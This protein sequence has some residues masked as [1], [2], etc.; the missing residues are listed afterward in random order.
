MMY[1]EYVNLV[2]KKKR[3]KNRCPAIYAR[4]RFTSSSQR[5]VLVVHANS[6]KMLRYVPFVEI[7][8]VGDMVDVSWMIL[9]RDWRIVTRAGRKWGV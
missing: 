3:K 6:S 7:W 4:I 5:F 2:R 8:T 9:T 1:V